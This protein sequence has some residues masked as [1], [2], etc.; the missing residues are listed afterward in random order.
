LS[1]RQASQDLIAVL[2][3]DNIG[4][5]LELN[6]ETDFVARSADFKNLA[7]EIT[8]AIL[9]AAKKRFQS[10]TPSSKDEFVSIPV[11]DWVVTE[12]DRTVKD[13]IAMTVG[14]LR[15]NIVIKRA[16]AIISSPQV[17]IQANVHP[18]FGTETVQ[19]GQFASIIGIT[20]EE[21]TSKFPTE[22]LAHQICQHII[23]MRPE[24]LG[25]PGT[26]EKTKLDL[27]DDK[28]FQD[29]KERYDV[30]DS[31]DV[32]STQVDENETQ[33]LRQSFMLSPSMTVHEYLNNH[34]A[35][36]AWFRRY[37]LGEESNEQN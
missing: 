15:E 30:E 26:S 2:T 5:L 25:T 18:H 32:Q 12:K 33:L 1:N 35:H 8:C 29:E 11:E 16:E 28:E 3:R 27:L 7:E 6:C 34:S 10:K 31:A 4:A 36:L 37:E 23:G 13:A 9:E 19:M 24:T 21:T 22:K 14:Q 17:I 20:R